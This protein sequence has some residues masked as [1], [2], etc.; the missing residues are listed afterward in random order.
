M[1]MPR[2]HLVVL[3]ILPLAATAQS[4]VFID[5][6]RSDEVFWSMTRTAMQAAAEDLNFQLEVL[7][8][9]RDHLKMLAYAEKVAS[10]ET[11]PD[12]VV[13]VNEKA[14][15][16]RMLKRLVARGIKVMLIM[17]TFNR[18]Q[19][20]VFGRPRERYSDW[21]GA[22]EPDQVE[23]GRSIARKLVEM[24]RSRFGS[25]LPVLAIAA[26]KRTPASVQRVMGLREII[27]Q[28]V[29]TEIV[30]V[31]HSRW[32]EGRARKQSIGLLRRYPRTRLIWAAND[33][34]ALGALRSARALGLSPGADVLVGGLNWS[35]AALEK[36]YDGSMA[37]TVGGHFLSGAWAL[38][39][40]RDYFDGRDFVAT[41]LHVKFAMS[42]ITSDNID[43]YLRVFGDQNWGRIN[44]KE[45]LDHSASGY[46]FDLTRVL[47]SAQQIG[48]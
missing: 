36:V 48:P 13:I 32:D 33:P 31:I 44:F 10:R 23:A 4:V 14:M 26:D 16:G 20:K 7:V 21:I 22:L 9:E 1:L 34:M 47:K 5:P 30:Q 25:S 24:G 38:V 8:S 19:E 15:A 39:M 2:F 3:L 6:G 17:N 45:F 40:L 12:V 42:P 43:A 29:G 46:N 41:G 18:E 37:V 35:S 27:A 28:Q 11:P